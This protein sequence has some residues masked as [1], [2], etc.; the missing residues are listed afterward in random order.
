VNPRND[1]IASLASYFGSYAQRLLDLASV[2]C[3]LDVAEDLP[4]YPLDPKFRQELFLA[5]KE[6]LTNVVRHAAATQVWVRISVKDGQILVVLADNGRGFDALTR[7]AGADGVANMKD[8]LQALGGICEISS[9]T[10]RG[11]AVHF[12][13]PLPKR[14][15]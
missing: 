4:D 8:R 15:V 12:R 7:Q 6:A 10:P 3:G 5:F 1:T 2:A 13:A 14:L 9:N 11:T